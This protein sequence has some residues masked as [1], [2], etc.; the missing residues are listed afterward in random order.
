MTCFGSKVTPLRPGT[1]FGEPF[2]SFT[3]ASRGASS[4]LL[5]AGLSA[6]SSFFSSSCGTSE[7]F[8]GFIESAS[9]YAG[10]RSTTFWPASTNTTGADM[11]GLA[12]SSIAERTFFSLTSG[13]TT[14]TSRGT[15]SSPPRYAATTASSAFARSRDW[16]GSG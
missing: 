9:A 8:S 13:S 5:V 1:T 3:V 7:P 15:T 4:A 2:T 16:P 6:A 12:K 10:G 11:A 14:S